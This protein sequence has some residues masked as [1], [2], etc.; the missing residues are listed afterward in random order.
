MNSAPDTCQFGRSY[1]VRAVI[2]AKNRVKIAEYAQTIAKDVPRL[3]LLTYV[4][5]IAVRTML[6]I[7]N[8]STPEARTYIAVPGVVSAARL[9][10]IGF[11]KT[12]PSG[13]TT[14]AY[15]I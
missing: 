13:E 3:T 11:C 2:P 12:N 14:P 15:K 9:L 7:L 5:P 8:T 4:K 10:P 1:D 6:Q